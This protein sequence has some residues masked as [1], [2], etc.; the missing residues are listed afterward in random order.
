MPSTDGHDR[1]D[2][3]TG[4]I[5]VDSFD[6]Y[7]LFYYGTSFSF[8]SEGFRTGISVQR[9]SQAI[10]INSAKGPLSSTIICPGC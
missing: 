9:I 3:V 8:V 10:T 6:A 5:S 2:V 1:G 4:T 7:V